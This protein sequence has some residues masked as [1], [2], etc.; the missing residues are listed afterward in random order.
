[1]F[2]ILCRIVSIFIGGHF[3][4]IIPSITAN[5]ISEV[6]DSIS[7][8]SVFIHNSS[9]QVDGLYSRFQ[10]LE[11]NGLGQFRPVIVEIP[12]RSHASETIWLAWRGNDRRPVAEPI[13]DLRFVGNKYFIRWRLAKVFN[14]VVDAPSPVVSRLT[15]RI[16]QVD[17]CPQLTNGDKYLDANCNDLTKSEEHKPKGQIDHPPVGR[18]FSIAVGSVALNGL[19]FV[20]A[21]HILD[22]RRLVGVV[23]LVIGN[24]LNIVA[25][26]LWWLTFADPATWSWWL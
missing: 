9:N 16:L 24:A 7:G 25:F 8:E 11:R 4:S 19:L 18:R 20:V 3:I 15:P 1:M 22:K 14:S 21:W 12:V 13:D 23:M 17:V 26:L 2:G 10:F 6:C 5:V